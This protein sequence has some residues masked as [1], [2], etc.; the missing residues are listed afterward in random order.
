MPRLYRTWSALARAVRMG[1]LGVAVF[2]IAAAGGSSPLP[3]MW[4]SGC[5]AL[6]RA[7]PTSRQARRISHEPMNRIFLG[8]EKHIS[9]AIGSDSNISDS[10][11]H[12]RRSDPIVPRCCPRGDG[13]FEVFP[14]GKDFSGDCG[15]SGE[16]EARVFLISP[17]RRARLSISHLRE[18]GIF[19]VMPIFNAHSLFASRATGN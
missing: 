8:V 12:R 9:K 13:V 16:K 5:K 2:E 18:E 11:P 15:L 17:S 3:G 19:E 14:H 6:G 1:G 10:H 7:S 4:R